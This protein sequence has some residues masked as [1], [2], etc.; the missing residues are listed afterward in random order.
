MV[1][2]SILGIK[3]GIGLGRFGRV[4]ELGLDNFGSFCPKV[5]HFLEMSESLLMK[6]LIH[7]GRRC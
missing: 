4:Q 2:W 7:Y 1:F 6:N 5:R 3:I